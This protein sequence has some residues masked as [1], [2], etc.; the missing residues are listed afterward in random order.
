MSNL[1]KRKIICSSLTGILLLAGVS[2]SSVAVEDH[3]VKKQNRSQ[4]E[5]PTYIEKT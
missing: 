2:A 5:R 3:L 4:L 1:T